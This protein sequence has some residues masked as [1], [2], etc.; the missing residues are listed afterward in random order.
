[1]PTAAITRPVPATLRA[2]DE[3]MYWLLMIPSDDGDVAL[4]SEAVTAAVVVSRAASRI[5]PSAWA[6]YAPGLDR[7][8]SAGGV[9]AA[10][11]GAPRELETEVEGEP[12]RTVAEVHPGRPL[13][14]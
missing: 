3:V 7:L 8:V 6:A 13:D 10:C 5:R 4:S 9:R 12:V 14:Q 2:V 1:M 11:T